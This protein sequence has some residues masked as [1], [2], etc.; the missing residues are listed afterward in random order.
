VSLRDPLRSALPYSHGI[1]IPD[2]V[3]D[4]YLQRVGFD[5]QDARL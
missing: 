1:K 5:C 3:T 2:E 4:Y